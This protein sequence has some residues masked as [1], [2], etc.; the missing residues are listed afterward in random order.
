MATARSSCCTPGRRDRAGPPRCYRRRLRDAGATFVR[1]DALGES[2]APSRERGPPAGGRP[3][4]STAGTR[5]PTWPWSAADGRLLAAVAAADDLAPAGRAGRRDGPARRPRRGRPGPRPVSADD[6]GRRPRSGPTR[7]PGP[8]R[9]PTSR[10]LRAAFA[11]RRLAPADLSS[12][13][14]IAPVRAGTDRGWGVASSAARASTRPGSRPTDGPPGWPRSVRSRAIGAAAATSAMAALWVRPSGPATGVGR[15]PSW[16]GRVPAYFGLRRPLDVTRV[17]TRP[18]RRAPVALSPVVFRARAGGDAVARSS[19]I[20]SP[21]SSSSMAGRD[22]PS[23]APGRRRTRTWSW[24]A[25]SS[26][27]ATAL[28]GTDRRRD[29]GGRAPRRPSRGSTR[30][31]CSARRSWARPAA[32]PVA[33]RSRPRRLAPSG[34][35]SS[36]PVLPRPAERGGRPTASGTVRPTR[37]PSTMQSATPAAADDG[38]WSPPAPRPERRPRPDHHA[39]RL[40]GARRLDRPA[41][42]REGARWQGALRLGLHRLLPRLADRHRGR[43]RDRRSRRPRPARSRSAWGCSGSGSSSADSRRRCDAHRRPVHPGPRRRDDPADRLR[44]HRPQPAR[45]AAAQMFATLSTAWILPGRHRPGRRRA[46]RRDARLAVR[47]PRASC[48]SSRSPAF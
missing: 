43:R 37:H 14:R 24:P 44:R 35:P 2:R 26:E 21:T 1:V 25:A 3:R 33:E 10:R 46:G 27:A 13:M 7:S 36:G 17:R 30:R 15:G 42:R 47:L 16:S 4:A 39:R 5:R 23:P 28:R 22:H 12:T 45:V 40:R 29:P 6:S 38:L 48:R 20:G 8:T 18:H 41:H 34:D 11:A 19:S 9:P 32:G 31:R